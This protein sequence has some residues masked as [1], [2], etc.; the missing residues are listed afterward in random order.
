MVAKVSDCWWKGIWK[1]PFN[2][3][4]RSFLDA[5]A[6]DK[7]LQVIAKVRMFPKMVLMVVD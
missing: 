5:M 4:R 6:H 1:V 3:D 7:V 2:E